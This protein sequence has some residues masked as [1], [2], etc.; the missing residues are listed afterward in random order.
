MSKRDM[1]PSTATE[2]DR[3]RDRDKVR[4]TDGKASTRKVVNG[5][6]HDSR[7]LPSNARKLSFRV[8]GVA[9]GG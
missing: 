8:W 2:T 5:R 4:D 6:V 3:D 1:W 9:A 7:T